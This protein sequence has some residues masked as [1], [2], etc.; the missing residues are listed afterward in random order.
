MKSTTISINRSYLY[1]YTHRSDSLFIVLFHMHASIPSEQG[2][3]K[4]SANLINMYSSLS[5]SLSL[6]VYF[7]GRVDGGGGP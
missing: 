3:R 1:I 5:L 4:E 2:R 6:S 7:S